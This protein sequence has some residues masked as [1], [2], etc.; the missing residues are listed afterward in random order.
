ML[1]MWYHRLLKSRTL[2]CE[3]RVHVSLGSFDL[4]RS[5]ATASMLELAYEGLNLGFEDNN[6]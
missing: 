4:S 3:S 5:L 6:L 1:V 2:S